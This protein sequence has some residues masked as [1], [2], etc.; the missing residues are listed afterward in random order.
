MEKKGIRVINPMWYP[1]VTDKE[2]SRLCE[3]VSDLS[4]VTQTVNVKVKTEIRSPD[5]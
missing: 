3:A 5:L 2:S 1:N 4:K